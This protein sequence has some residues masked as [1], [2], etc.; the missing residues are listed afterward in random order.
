MDRIIVRTNADMQRV[1]DWSAKLTGVPVNLVFP[2]AEVEFVEELSLLKFRDEGQGFVSFELWIHGKENTEYAKLVSWRSNVEEFTFEDVKIEAEGMK[3]ATL[4]MI[5]AQNN[6]LVKT[7]GKFRALML[8]ASYYRE[9]VERTKVVERRSNPKKRSSRKGSNRR[10]LTVRKY[11]VSEELLS[12][13]P[14]P[15]RKY[16][17]HTESFGV[18]GH[19]RRY[20]SGKTVWVRPY[21]KGEPS[22][23]NDKEYYV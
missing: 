14:Q 4:G 9:E 17:K 7:V 21:T 23:R 11:T 3:K 20:K 13:L 5:L 18:R 15:K 8:F 6:I 19:Y 12:E 16:E 22:K 2:E 1:I 10:M